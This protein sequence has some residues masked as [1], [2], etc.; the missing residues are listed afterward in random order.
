VVECSG[1]Y[2]KRATHPLPRRRLPRLLLS[3][4]GASGE[5]VDATIVAGINQNSLTGH[6]WS[7]PP[8]A[9]PMPS[10]RCW[11]C[12]IAKSASIKPAD[13]AALGDERPAA[14]RRLSPRRP[15]PHR[16]AMQ[17]IIP[18]ST[19]LARGI[20]RLLPQL[21]GKVQAKAIRVPTHHVSAIDLTLSTQRP[22]SA[23]S[24]N[25]LL[26]DAA[27][28]AQG[29]IAYSEAAQPRSIS[30]TTP[31]RPLSM[32]ARPAPPAPIW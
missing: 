10:C 4:P 25:A 22:V 17:S 32:A 12:S 11:I 16:S 23:H 9:R 7:L 31:I 27:R 18:V 3:H 13:H 8:P 15:A 5:D 14:D 28:P 2:G 1:I 21:A 29:L 19:G 20:E 24:I 6:N 30:I 26:A